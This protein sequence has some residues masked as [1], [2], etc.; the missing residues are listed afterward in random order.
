MFS[1]NTGDRTSA[2]VVRRSS[3]LAVMASVA[4]VVVGAIIRRAVAL[5]LEADPA[6]AG[7]PLLGLSVLGAPSAVCWH[8]RL[9]GLV[10]DP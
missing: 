3:L 5:A 2:L 8:H 4:C 1:T 6:A 7:L 9:A 10:L